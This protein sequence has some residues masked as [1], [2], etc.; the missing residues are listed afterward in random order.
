MNASDL[1][2]AI[3]DQA[4]SALTACELVSLPMDEAIT[5][6]DP[7]IHI[8]SEELAALGHLI[9]SDMATELFLRLPSEAAGDND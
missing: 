3:S 6:D 9:K 4:L 7:D 1:S 2:T 5:S 8:L